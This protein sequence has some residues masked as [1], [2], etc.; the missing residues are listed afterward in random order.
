M[1]D[2]SYVAGAR[3]R[4]V[5]VAAAVFVL[6][7]RARLSCPRVHSCP[8]PSSALCSS[9]PCCCCLF[10]LADLKRAAA[11]GGKSDAQQRREERGEKQRD[12]RASAAAAPLHSLPSPPQRPPSAHSNATQVSSNLKATN[13]SVN[14]GEA[15]RSELEQG[16]S[17]SLAQLLSSASLHTLPA[18]TDLSAPLLPLKLN[19]DVTSRCIIGASSETQARARWS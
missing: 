5:H 19:K 10:Q 16:A 1:R 14:D 17:G 6:L 3:L 15:E 9:S 12:A 2:C 18:P 4:S 13:T 7:A 11:D 8:L